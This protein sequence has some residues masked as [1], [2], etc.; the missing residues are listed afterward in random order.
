MSTAAVFTPNEI[1]AFWRDAGPK[2][3]FEADPEFDA[4]VRQRF[5]A[6]HTAAAAGKFTD[7]E[8]GADGALALL[9]VLD[10]FPRNMF[11]GTA[12]AFATDALAREVARRA[13]ARGFEGKVEPAMR[14][15]FYL[16][17]MHSEELA[18]QQYCVDLYRAA[19]DAD[20]LKWAEAHLDPILRFGRFPHRN[21][22]LGRTSSPE[23]LAFLESGGFAG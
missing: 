19:G 14:G 1:V 3:W 4:Q 7:W 10:Q 15:F 5:L 21:E 18:D 23:E 8:A 16:P 22:I 9:I 2:R 6:T 20:G 13:I 12:Q 17:F 11:R